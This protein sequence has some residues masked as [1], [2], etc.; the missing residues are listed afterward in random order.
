MDKFPRLL[1]K[2]FIK[3]IIA[4]F[5]DLQVSRMDYNCIRIILSLVCSALDPAGPIFVLPGVPRLEIGDADIVDVIHTD[6]NL[7]GYPDDAGLIDYYPNSHFLK[8]VQPGCPS[9]AE[10]NIG[11]LSLKIPHQNGTNKSST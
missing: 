6:P 4:N 8:F 3:I 2:G 1:Q 9:V 10:P 11:K 7:L 5:P